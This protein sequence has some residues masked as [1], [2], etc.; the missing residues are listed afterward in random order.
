VLGE[1]AVLDAEQIEERCRFAAN[2]AFPDDEDE[3]AFAE[4]LMNR[5][6]LQFNTDPLL[7]RPSGP[8]LLARIP[9]FPA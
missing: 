3:V 6:V 9:D 2:A 5:L 4:Q 1:L 7:P 8:R